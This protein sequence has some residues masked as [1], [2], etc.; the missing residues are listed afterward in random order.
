[1]ENNSLVSIVKEVATLETMLI[2][3]GGE[4]TPEIEQMLTVKEVNLPAKVDSYEAM[5]GRLEVIEGLY[6]ERAKLFSSAAKS[7]ANAQDTLKER[8]KFAMKELGVTEL[9]GHDIRFKLSASKPKL[10]IEDEKLIPKEY[11]VQVISEEIEKDRL[12]ED[13]KIGS[14]S[15]AKL[16]ETFSLRKYVNKKG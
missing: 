9:M 3:S 6:K 2:E 8:L 13:L 12:T 15:G 11:K 7:L 1:M 10:V 5:L 4:L 14:V 16:E